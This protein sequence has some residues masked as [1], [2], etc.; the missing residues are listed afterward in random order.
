MNGR[1]KLPADSPAGAWALNL[2]T[3][4]S[5]EEVVIAASF[6]P[7]SAGS[8]ALVSQNARAAANGSF[9]KTLSSRETEW[10]KRLADVPQ[11]LSFAVAT[12]DPRGATPAEIEKTYYRA[13]V[14]LLADTLP[15]MPENGYPF[16]QASCGKASLWSE[17]AP[18][19]RASSQWESGIA[20]QLLARVDP[21]TAMSAL[22]GLMALVDSNGVM[23]GEGLPTRFA[24]TAWILYRATGNLDALTRTYPALKRL[25]LWKASDPRWLY[26]G[27]TPTDQKDSEFVVH[28]LMDMQY[29]IR[30]G[31][32]LGMDD[33]VA[34]WKG[35]IDSLRGD[36]DRWFW[37]GGGKKTYRI[38]N[39][40]S[41]TR[42]EADGA[43]CLEALAL[44]PSLL[45]DAERDYL[46]RLFRSQFRADMPFLLPALAGFPKYNLA[47]RGIWQYGAPVEAAQMAE[48]S[49]RDVTLA[50]EFSENYSQSFPPSASGVI[51]SVFGAAQIIEGSLWH[52]GINLGDGVPIVMSMPNALG[53]RGL[54]FRRERMDVVLDER[55][56]RMEVQGE[57]LKLLQIPIGMQ[58]TP[59]TGGKP[60]W[61]GSMPS[62]GG[63]ILAPEAI[64][65]H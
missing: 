59:V 45:M 44:P 36:Y 20:I 4:K 37:E 64:Q 17:G 23:A 12:L 8:D 47:Q 62:R 21:D 57:A 26:K 51:P 58:S 35:H 2:G 40:S 48:A 10:N 46:L 28:A 50:G 30:I 60:R 25:L 41:Q 42:A 32:A 34:F 13:W 3:V 65:G 11:P 18:K 16:P 5:G 19:A 1:N 9:E 63:I 55:A 29:A 49:L 61:Y 52:N 14:F 54:R 33:E 6:A 56:G 27:S 7:F 38:Y 39:A 22:Q 53:V 24:Q 15:P 43:W 31:K